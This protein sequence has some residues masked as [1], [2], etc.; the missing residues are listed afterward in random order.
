M[1]DF[2]SAARA[3]RNAACFSAVSTT[4]RGNCGHCLVAARIGSARCGTVGTTTSNGP[5]RSR[6]N[7]TVSANTPS[8]RST[9]PTRLPGGAARPAARRAG[10]APPAHSDADHGPLSP[11]DAPHRCRA[12]RRAA[13]EPGLERQQRQDV[14]DVGAHDP[15]T[16]RPPAHADGETYSTIAIAGSAARTRRAMPRVKPGL[17]MT[18]RT[19]G[20]FA[21]TALAVERI[22]RR[23]LG[24]RRG[25]A[26]Q[27]R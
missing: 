11:G 19:C 16:P 8:S 24:M 1:P 22:R 13:G 5:T 14:I 23:I 12:V 7:A 10:G 6:S 25:M 27:I 2:A 15:R 18:T 17:S 20:R 4:I 3:M 9:S 26:A 21:T